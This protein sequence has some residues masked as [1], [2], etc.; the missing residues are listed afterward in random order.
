MDNRKKILTDPVGQREPEVGFDGNRK[1]EIWRE[2]RNRPGSGRR[3]QPAHR[4]RL[5][6]SSQGINSRILF[7][8]TTLVHLLSRAF[9]AP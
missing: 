7:P 3:V 1:L 6:A 4:F 8:L 2:T 9:R 5:G